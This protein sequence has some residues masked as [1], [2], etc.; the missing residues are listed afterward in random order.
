MQQEDMCQEELSRVG[1]LER[2]QRKGK[3]LLGWAGQGRSPEGGDIL[4]GTSRGKSL[5]GRRNNHC[6]GLRIRLDPHSTPQ[7]GEHCHNLRGH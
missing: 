7:C 5:R 6:R 2:W 4:H 3:D 1:I